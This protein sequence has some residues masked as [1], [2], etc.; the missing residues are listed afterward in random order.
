METMETLR[1]RIDSAQGLHSLVRTMKTMAMV[2]I[3]HY[4]AA[5]AAL[6]DYAE[7]VERGFQ[8]VLREGLYSVTLSNTSPSRPLGVIVIGSEQGMV[9]QFN[10]RM[11]LYAHARLREMALPEGSVVVTLGNRMASRL[12][13]LGY[14]VED[15]LVVPNSVHGIS[16]IVGQLL[17]HIDRWRTQE[18]PIEQVWLFFN[19]TETSASYRPTHLQLLPLDSTWIAQITD[20]PWESRSLPIYRM[21][22]EPL[23]SALV[24]QYLFAGLY[25]AVAQSLASENASRLVAM[26]AAEQNIEERLDEFQMRLQQQRQ[27]SIMNE[28]LDVIAGYVALTDVSS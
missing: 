5:V 23:F 2:N 16:G 25:R 24:R 6:D 26:Q 27:T 12:Q 11:A 18:P 3:R 28:L 8:V 13:S 14:A 10:E 15:S 1:R 20:R 4:E 7:T 21:E 19:Q 9:G 22:W 17:V